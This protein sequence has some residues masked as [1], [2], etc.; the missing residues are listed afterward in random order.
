ML[1][2][3]PSPLSSWGPRQCLCGVPKSDAKRGRE[4]THQHMN[5]DTVI[6]LL[7]QFQAEN[8]AKFHTLTDAGKHLAAAYCDGYA[9]GLAT[10]IRNIELMEDAPL[11]PA[12]RA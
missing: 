12:D 1:D 8:Q 9:Q 6:K 7:S 5:K 10:A 11:A 2:A 3:G 4:G